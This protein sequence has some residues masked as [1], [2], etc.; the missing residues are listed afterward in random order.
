MNYASAAKGTKPSGPGPRL[1]HIGPRWPALA[2][3]YRS[4]DRQPNRL[5]PVLAVRPLGERVRERADG[6]PEACAGP[7]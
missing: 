2:G 3:V 7:R 5:T 1:A 4:L 6:S